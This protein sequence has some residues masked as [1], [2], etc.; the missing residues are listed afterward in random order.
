MSDYDYHLSGR[1]VPSND[2]S[3]VVR[4]ADEYYCRGGGV[5][6]NNQS[7]VV[8]EADKI[9]HFNLKAGGGLCFVLNSSQS[10]KSSLRLHVAHLLE[11]DSVEVIQ[12]DLTGIDI[13]SPEKFDRYL[14][15]EIRSEFSSAE[16]E[17]V[18]SEQ[19]QSDSSA[20]RFKNF[21]EK[22]ILAKTPK[23][24]VIFFDEIGKVLEC[25]FPIDDFV[26]FI[27]YCHERAKHDPEYKRLS[28]CILGI[29]SLDDLN[30]KLSSNSASLNLG[31]FIDLEPFKLGNDLEPLK[32]GLR[33]IYSDKDIDLITKEIL[34]W[35]GG[36]PF[37][38]QKLFYL[39][40][41]EFGRKDRRNVEQIV[42][43]CII[44]DWRGQDKP[45]HLGKIKDKIINQK[46][47][48]QI[49][50]LYQ[51]ILQGDKITADND[52]IKRQLLLSGIVKVEDNKLKV[53]NRINE[54]V[55]N[56]N[57]LKTQFIEIF[58]F[59]E[60]L[61]SWRDSKP[62]E[63]IWLLTIDELQ[64]VSEWENEDLD[65]ELI[66]QF[67]D[68]SKLQIKAIQLREREIKLKVSELKSQLDRE[69]ED[70]KAV[71]ERNQ[72]LTETKKKA[73]MLIVAGT[74]VLVPSLLGS[75]FLGNLA[76]QRGVTIA[77]QSKQSKMFATIKNILYSDSRSEDP[78]S[79]KIKNILYSELEEHLK[80]GDY[81]KADELTARIIWEEA[82]TV[83]EPEFGPE[84]AENFPCKDLRVIDKPWTRY[85]DGG[86][87]F[88][89]Q[90][91]IWRSPEVNGD[92]HKFI[93][94]VGWLYSE[95]TP[96]GDVER[97]FH[98]RDNIDY[99][100]KALEGSLP[101]L[102]S[103]I[104]GDLNNR[105]AYLERIVECGL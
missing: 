79:S 1:N 42:R 11:E 32:K 93:E 80:N 3:Y 78:T 85:S 13:Y 28:F 60:K 12:A 5:P 34:Y 17:D 61:K 36:Q 52:S 19:N 16:D 91:R 77:E 87:G 90:S 35:T 44:V 48:Y 82:G 64:K 66:R 72:L 63:E 10:G 41:K 47:N 20:V 104:G 51:Q 95:R 4:E 74:A 103:Y 105:E 62:K 99:S 46:D 56:I 25:K 53:Y 100:S 15:N 50:K 65:I 7:Y 31:E 33:G 6:A 59:K 84:H 55:F 39:V 49:L 89:A 40:R 2:Q 67:I 23:N 18:W 22:E 76:F 9:L 58:S 97:F 14:F 73:K 83:T 69:Q 96:K 88:S 54:A 94:R 37:L 92:I 68:A 27:R 86:L 75:V 26:G 8:R 29:A 24:I 81:K 70:K 101:L 102:V 30:S 43:E 71:E 98:H 57:W 21:V 38:T 45:P